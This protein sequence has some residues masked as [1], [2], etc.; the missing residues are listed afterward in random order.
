MHDDLPDPPASQLLLKDD[1]PLLLLPR[2]L[3]DGR[4]VDVGSCVYSIS[5]M[6]YSLFQLCTANLFP[7]LSPLTAASK[8]T[9][10]YAPPMN[11]QP[12]T[13]WGASR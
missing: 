5:M 1:L 4:Q 11:Y 8:E 3:L 12:A 2:L 13:Y 6:R 10:F 7:S 9:L